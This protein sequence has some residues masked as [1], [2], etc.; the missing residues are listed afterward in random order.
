M[1]LP[2]LGCSC[3]DKECHEQS[4]VPVE[5]AESGDELII[6]LAGQPNT[7]KSTIFNRLTGLRQ[8][9]GNWPGKT[10]SRREGFS[11]SGERDYRI[12]DLPGTYGLSANSLEE[13]IARDYIVFGD[14]DIV[15]A[16]VNGAAIE[17]GLYLIAELALLDVPVVIA[18]NMMDVAE[19]EGR[20]IDPQKLS[21]VTGMPVI[22]LIAS[23]NHGISELL[24]A[25]DNIDPADLAEQGNKPEVPPE[26]S[27]LSVRIPSDLTC[28]WPVLWTAS[29]LLE[30]DRAVTETVL[31]STEM[32]N[33]QTEIIE[34][35]IAGHGDTINAII[36]GR[37]QWIN[38]ICCEAVSDITGKG[39]LTTRLDKWFLHPVWG[40][41]TA[42]V[43]VP[44][45]VV[46][47]FGITMLA[48]GSTLKVALEKGPSIKEA[49]PGM[50]GSLFADGILLGAGWVVVLSVAIGIIYT[51]FHFLEDVGYLARISYH[52]DPTL[53][54][55]GTSGKAA[56][57]LLMSFACNAIAVAGTRVVET[58]RQRLSAIIMLPFLPCAGQSMVAALFVLAFFPPLTAATIIVI[59]TLTNIA[60]GA[61]AGKAVAHFT[62]R[63]G[64]DGLI[65][66]LP[67]FHRPNFRTIFRGVYTQVTMFIRRAGTVIFCAVI[68]VWVISYFPHGDIHTSFLY[69]LG[70]LLEPA[71]QLIG[72]D[73]RF[74][75]ALL[76]SFIAKETTVGTLAVLFALSSPDSQDI[77]KTIG[78]SITLPAALA[79]VVTSH[80]FI[81]CLATIATLRSEIGSDK[82]TAVLLAGMLFLAFF[83]AF[84]IYRI[85]SMLL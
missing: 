5:P 79:F 68:F 16:V 57:P 66:E 43:A 64:A 22:P 62:P 36:H 6:A 1:N 8:R 42:F 11:K 3:C 85:S 35:F 77:I 2:N 51:L 63:S 24:A 32:D 81:P 55:A 37:Q 53:R 46:I 76:S 73:W 78:E 83:L 48:M 9:V 4:Q 75:V 13:E 15:V 38:T 14:R 54:R 49:W 39:S 74:I 71:G 84:V 52:I 30:N 12:V 17:R 26:V 23:R 80:F 29:K 20:K 69:Q 10:V 56:I 58:R 40:R 45:S 72:L 59:L 33:N 19:D 50:L 27:E 21:E 61:L 70:M 82:W 34:T 18:L 65:L 25:L 67:L 47:V 41:I 31:S 7:G 60:V 44:L 28:K